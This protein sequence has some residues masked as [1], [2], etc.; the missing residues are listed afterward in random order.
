MAE[1]K[2]SSY[3]YSFTNY[4]NGSDPDE[5]RLQNTC[6]QGG[7]LLEKDPGVLTEPLKYILKK[8]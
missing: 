5:K 3:K 6:P 4:E 8:K 1:T 7:G 2:E